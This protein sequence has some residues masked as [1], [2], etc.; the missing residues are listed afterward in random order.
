MEIVKDSPK[1]AEFG[2]GTCPYF[3]PTKNPEVKTRQGECRINPPV[4]MLLPMQTLQGQTVGI[5]SVFPVIHETGWCGKHPRRIQRNLFTSFPVE[6][7]Q[8]N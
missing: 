3:S 1:T 6:P 4:L 8:D 5:Q 7:N 2:C